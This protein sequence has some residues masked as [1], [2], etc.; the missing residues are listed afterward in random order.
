MRHLAMGL[1]AAL[2]IATGAWAQAAPPAIDPAK[3]DLARQIVAAVGG[4]KQA[5]LQM[6]LMFTA[7]Q[8]AVAQS[9]PADVNQLQGP[10]F[11]LMGQE[12]VK[13]TPQMLEISTRAYADAYTEK[14]LR[15]ILAFQTSETG[16]AM[17]RKTP[18][19][20]AEVLAET[21]PLMLKLLP[22]IM[23]RVADKV[24]AEQHCTPRQRQAVANALTHAAA[25]PPG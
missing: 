5:E 7:M 17:V 20:R 6:R 18:A 9:L 8:K 1:A 13:L 16:Q 15:D 2:T 3:L 22:S 21:M 11:D 19:V 4:E 10:I 24:C 23:G 12:M 14:E 25:R